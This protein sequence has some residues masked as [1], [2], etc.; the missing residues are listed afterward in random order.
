MKAE[1]QKEQERTAEKTE[2]W[3]YRGKIVQLKKESFKFDHKIKIAEVVQ[4][5]G[6]VVMI[7]VAPD[8]KLL[9]V[10]QYR[11]AIKEIILELPAGTIEHDENPLLCAQREL[12][13]EIGFR[14]EKMT[15]LNGF[16]SAP[17]F[18]SEYLHLFLAED[19]IPS[20]LESDDDE[21]ID[22]IPL[23]IEECLDKIEKGE[24][25][26]AKTVSG[27]LIYERMMKK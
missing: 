10:R 5:P 22:L 15:P 8:G 9:L 16:Y 23:S 6:A 18:C 21:M 12:Q 1:Q 27:I 11:R 3:I 26:D 4:H 13:E 25:C 2:E 20:V 17:G 19:L 14:S 7:P 24:I